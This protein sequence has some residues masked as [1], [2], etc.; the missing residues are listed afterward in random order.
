[1]MWILTFLL[2]PETTQL[3]LEQIDDHF[4]SGRKAWKTSTSRNKKIGKGQAVD[5][6]GEKGV[7]I[8]CVE[9]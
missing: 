4:L 9:L 1:M 6:T 8:K 3:T 7:G 2:V 5:H